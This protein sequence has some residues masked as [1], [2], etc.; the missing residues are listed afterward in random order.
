[1]RKHAAATRSPAIWGL[2]VKSLL[3]FAGTLALAITFLLSPISQPLRSALEIFLAHAVGSFLRL[4]EGSVS[5]AG[6]IITLGGFSAE[7]VPACTGLFTTSIFV[8]AVLAYPASPKSKIW[9]IAMGVA[10]IMAINWL[11]ILTLLLIGAYYYPAFEFSHLI[12]WRSL[13]IFAAAWLWLFWVQRFAH[14]TP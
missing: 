14:A 8:A 9:G 7:I 12:V 11:R 10:G 1:M 3:V 6:S 4:F 13:V 2:A 5:I